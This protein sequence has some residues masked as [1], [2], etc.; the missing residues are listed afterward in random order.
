MYLI[1]ASSYLSP[2]RVQARRG[3]GLCALGDTLEN[4]RIMSLQSSPSES[5]I[6]EILA[7]F[8]IL[9]WTVAGFGLRQQREEM[10]AVPKADRHLPRSAS[11]NVTFPDLAS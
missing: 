2:H 9:Y 4:W 5:L 11:S 3:R 7:H 8:D 1:G 6:Y 10:A